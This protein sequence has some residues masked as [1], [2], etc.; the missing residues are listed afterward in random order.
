MASRCRPVSQPKRNVAPA[1]D[2]KSAVARKVSTTS[3]AL[4]GTKAI[5]AS[6]PR[7][8]R[9][10]Q[11]PEAAL[12]PVEV[13]ERLLELGHG[14][15]RPQGRRR[16]PRAGRGPPR[17]EPGGGRENRFLRGVV[18]GQAQV[19]AGAAGGGGLGGFDGP[20]PLWREGGGPAQHGQGAAR[21]GRP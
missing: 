8:R 16:E 2:T 10:R 18:N 6:F 14:E 13:F 3:G 9:R 20:A 1:T 21:A 12:A 7:Q 19:E 17:V 4:S 5:G 11:T 15:V